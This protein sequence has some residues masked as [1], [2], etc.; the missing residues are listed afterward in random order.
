MAIV[1][2]QSNSDRK[3]L[4]VVFAPSVKNTLKTVTHTEGFSILTSQTRRISRTRRNPVFM[5]EIQILT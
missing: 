1:K 2:R 4:A 3:G 5:V